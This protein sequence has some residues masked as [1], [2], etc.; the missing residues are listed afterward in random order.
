ML[1]YIRKP[2]SYLFAEWFAPSRG[3]IRVTRVTLGN[4]P[5][6]KVFCRFEVQAK[7]LFLKSHRISMVAKG[8]CTDKEIN[9]LV[10]N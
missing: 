6:M 7:T 3:Q 4:A 1:P 9:Q 2:L 8:H 5:K 10:S